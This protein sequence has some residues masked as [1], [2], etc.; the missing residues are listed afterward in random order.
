M[1]K[2]NEELKTTF[3]FATHDYKVIQYVQRKIVLED[4]QVSEDELKSPDR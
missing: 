4:G 2:L 1:H 3:I